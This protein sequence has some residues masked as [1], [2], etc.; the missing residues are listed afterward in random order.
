MGLKSILAYTNPITI[1]M[2]IP[3]VC[4]II[5]SVITNNIVK[6][7]AKVIKSVNEDIMD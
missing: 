1:V 3:I 6:N 7:T 5:L 4:G 2:G